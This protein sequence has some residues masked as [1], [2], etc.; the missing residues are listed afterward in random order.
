MLPYFALGMSDGLAEYHAIRAAYRSLPRLSYVA[1]NPR[2]EVPAIEFEGHGIRGVGYRLETRIANPDR[3]YRTVLW[4]AA[5]H[6]Y[7]VWREEK[8]EGP[9]AEMHRGDLYSS[10]A[11]VFESSRQAHQSTFASIGKLPFV[12]AEFE[13]TDSDID[14]DMAEHGLNYFERIPDIQINGRWFRQIAAYYDAN[15]E[16]PTRSVF[17]YDPK[18]KLVLEY[19]REVKENGIFVSAERIV[20]KYR[21]AKILNKRDITH[22][23]KPPALPKFALPPA[24]DP[25]PDRPVPNDATTLAALGQALMARYRILTTYR[26]SVTTF[27]APLTSRPFQISMAMD[28]EVGSCFVRRRPF[29]TIA[30]IQGKERGLSWQVSARDGYQSTRVGRDGQLGI[31][32]LDAGGAMITRAWNPL[33]SLDL[34]KEGWTLR[35]DTWRDEPMRVLSRAV[36][37]ANPSHVPRPPIPAG[38]EEVW[39]D[40]AT[41]LVVRSRWIG[42]PDQ[43]R[44]GLPIY[45]A[46]HAPETNAK[47]RAS[48]LTFH[49]P[50]IDP[51]QMLEAER[52]ANASQPAP[53]TFGFSF[54]GRF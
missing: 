6:K 41:G 17:T 21:N 7:F 5:P 16:F 46:V 12:Y 44:N 31:W 40:V 35:T 25:V 3:I 10:N 14:I 9:Q 2:K 26:D 45:D 51:I 47:L 36:Q 23:G 19:R 34:E 32:Y 38:T 53:R 24:S 15:R 4:K 49:P 28:R 54:D 30:S 39:I 33:V 52:K 42:T 18:T 20:F 22:I 13:E 27:A 29:E 1:A 43:V 11:Q 50:V 48:D 8:P 37:M